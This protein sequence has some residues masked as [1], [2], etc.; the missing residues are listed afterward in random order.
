MTMTAKIKSV[1]RDVSTR[2]S[3]PGTGQSRP[4]TKQTA[5]GKATGNARLRR[6]GEAGELKGSLNQFAKKI[7]D[8]I[9]S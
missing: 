7:R 2:P 4:P 6:E 5:A 3:R 8:A 1:V 9:R